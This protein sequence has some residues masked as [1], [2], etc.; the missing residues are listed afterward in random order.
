[1]SFQHKLQPENN[2][3]L[4][5]DA[6]FTAGRSFPGLLL[7]FILPLL[8]INLTGLIFSVGIAGKHSGLAGGFFHNAPAQGFTLHLQKDTGQSY[9]VNGKPA[10]VVTNGRGERLITGLPDDKQLEIETVRRL[11]INLTNNKA[12]WIIGST[13]R[14]SIPAGFPL[15]N[16][17]PRT[18]YFYRAPGYSY[19]TNST[20]L[21]LNPV[22]PEWSAFTLPKNTSAAV[23]VSARSLLTPQAAREAW[24]IGDRFSYAAPAAEPPAW[25]RIGTLVGSL[26][27]NTLLLLGLFC[28]ALISYFNEPPIY[29]REIRELIGY[30]LLNFFGTLLIF[31]VVNLLTLSAFAVF[32]PLLLLAVY[33]LMR[34]SFA[35]AVTVTEGA[36]PLRSIMRSLQLTRGRNLRLLFPVAG[37]IILTVF[38]STIALTVTA[39]LLGIPH[40]QLPLHLM[41]TDGNQLYL[42][43]RALLI[44]YPVFLGALSLLIPVFVKFFYNLYMDARIAEEDLAGREKNGFF[45]STRS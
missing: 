24:Q 33:L 11:A 29:L 4:F 2:S 12:A 23:R 21:R 10:T 37:L 17:A 32:P 18:V 27:L 41:L 30:N 5:R 45:T 39:N 36:S 9:F 38:L 14:T 40:Q 28:W 25:Q 13:V 15:S 20:D 31:A 8:V 35:P 26:L 3:R 6:L 43:P 16:P 19:T 34:L 44:F 42:W 1:M 7:L 22:H